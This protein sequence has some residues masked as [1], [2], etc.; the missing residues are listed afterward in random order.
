MRDGWV[1]RRSL[2]CCGATAVLG[3]S[4]QPHVGAAGDR[5][6]TARSPGSCVPY[7]LLARER[8]FT[9]VEQ[10]RASAAPPSFLCVRHG[11]E[12]R[13]QA[14]PRSGRSATLRA[15]HLLGSS[16]DEKTF[17]AVERDTPGSGAGRCS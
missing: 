14:V 6:S 15:L 12:R 7:G 17:I 8:S 2:G 11:A 9:A 13:R 10:G 3:G 5:R 16:A 4:S 1:E